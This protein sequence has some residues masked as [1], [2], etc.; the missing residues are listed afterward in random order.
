MKRILRVLL[1]LLCAVVLLIVVCDLRVRNF[2]RGRLSDDVRTLPHEHAALLLGTSSRLQGG[3]PNPYFEYRMDAAAE[4]FR[5]GKVDC[6]LVSGDNHHASYNEPMAMRKALL[7]RNIPDS[8]IFLDYAGFRTL[9]SVIRACEVFGQTSY[10]VVS[11]RFHNERAVYL[12]V[13]HGIDAVGYNARD[14]RAPGARRVRAREWLARVSACWDVLIGR[15]PHFL[16]DPVE[17]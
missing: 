13:R 16:G 3:S 10:I 9:D 2:A 14:V 5:A 12:A 6:I 1:I 15:G 8:L 4:L 17:M 7:D 11:Q